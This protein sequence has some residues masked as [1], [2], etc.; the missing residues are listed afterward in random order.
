VGSASKELIDAHT[1]P[2]AIS[3][4]WKSFYQNKYK[5]YFW[6]LMNDRLHSI[7]GS[8][9]RERTFS[10]QIT[11]VCFVLLLMWKQEII[12]SFNVRLVKLAGTTSVQT[13]ICLEM[14]FKILWQVC[15]CGFLSTWNSLSCLPGPFGLRRKF[16]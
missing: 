11:A 15:V 8:C 2:K 7:H 9:C 10:S 12:Y 5:V 1:F 6:Y 3:W 16:K 4:I 14:R 13:G